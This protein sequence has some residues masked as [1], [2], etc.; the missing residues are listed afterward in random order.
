MITNEL[1]D[2]I[3]SLI[4]RTYTVVIIILF[5]NFAVLVLPIELFFLD[6]ILQ[7]LARLDLY[8]VPVFWIA[9]DDQVYNFSKKK[10]KDICLSMK[11][12]F[13]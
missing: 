2:Y 1:K 5:I 7:L 12:L 9:I 11:M 3:L 10:I 8:F 4:M 13:Y 6:K